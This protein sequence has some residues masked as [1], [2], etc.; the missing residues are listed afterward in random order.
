[1]R[2]RRLDDRQ[3]LL[4]PL[5]GDA[6]RVDLAAEHVALD[7]EADEAVVD[8]LPGVDLVVRDRADALAWRRMAARSSAVEPP[9][10]T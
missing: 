8:L 3:R 10:S 5:G 1:M 6:Q 2:A 9:V 7:Q 4:G